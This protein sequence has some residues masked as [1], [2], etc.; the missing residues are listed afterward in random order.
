M[1][2]QIRR[3][4]VIIVSAGVAAVLSALI[5]M[6]GFK[7][8]LEHFALSNVALLFI[9]LACAIGIWLDYFLDAKILKS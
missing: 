8:T 3:L 5:I 7:T 9:S 1:S 4:I 6:V 2:I